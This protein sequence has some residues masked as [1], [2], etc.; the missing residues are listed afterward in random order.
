M[1][2]LSP[3]SNVVQQFGMTRNEAY[4]S[5]FYHRSSARCIYL[6]VYVDDTVLTD[7]DHRGILQ[8]KHYLCQ[9]F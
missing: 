4:H 7:S 2:T 9:H 6:V 3:F 5:S 8:L 1:G